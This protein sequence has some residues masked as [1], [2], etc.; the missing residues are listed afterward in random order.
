MIET[1]LA[2]TSSILGILFLTSEILGK[3]KCN[4]NSVADVIERIINACKR[5]PK[6][7]KP[8]FPEIPTE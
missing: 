8:P 4:L 2:I 3:S 7:D 1:I 6:C 5:K